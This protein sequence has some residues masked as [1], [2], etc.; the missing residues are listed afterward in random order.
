VRCG[1]NNNLLYSNRKV[2]TPEFPISQFS[3]S[4]LPAQTVFSSFKCDPSALARPFLLENLASNLS[5]NN[6]L[7]LKLNSGQSL[8]HHL[9]SP[10][11]PRSYQFENRSRIESIN[12]P[13]GSLANQP[14]FVVRPEAFP[15][16]IPQPHVPY[17]N[18]ML[19]NQPCNNY[20]INN[21]N[22]QTNQSVCCQCCFKKQQQV[23]YEPFE[24]IS[25][26]LKPSAPQNWT[27]R[28][29]DDSAQKQNQ[30]PNQFLQT[31]THT[32][33][34]FF[35]VPTPRDLQFSLR[36]SQQYMPPSPLSK[37]RLV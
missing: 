15:F 5:L 36:Y 35:S 23:A 12:S 22:I 28:T 2:L 34:E 37:Q 27:P 24:P 26:L 18:P 1:K 16:S 30:L 6:Q 31:F 14:E 19:L 21:M 8:S 33:A 10:V 32:P 29:G 11:Q 3:E 17:S 13:F 25:Y 9:A 20:F 4:F 7:L